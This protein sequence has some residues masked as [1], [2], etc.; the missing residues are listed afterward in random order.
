MNL[1][2]ASWMQVNENINDHMD[3]YQDLSQQYPD[4][5]SSDTLTLISTEPTQSASS[6]SLPPLPDS[7]LASDSFLEHA[8]FL[9]CEIQ[10]EVPDVLNKS[11]FDVG[12]STGQGS[13]EMSL[14]AVAWATY[15]GGP[16]GEVLANK[17]I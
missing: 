4:M 15:N 6:L 5:N 11:S 17:M 12:S 14:N 16:L 10:S 3:N 1:Y 13:N 7:F 9:S 2:N 8:S